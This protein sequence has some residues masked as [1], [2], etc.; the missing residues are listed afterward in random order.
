MFLGPTLRTFAEVIFQQRRK[1]P[2][3]DRK[4][5]R[6]TRHPHIQ[7]G[8]S[9]VLRNLLCRHLAANNNYSQKTVKWLQKKKKKNQAAP[10]FVL[11]FIGGKPSLLC[12]IRWSLVWK[13]TGE[14][15]VSAVHVKAHRIGAIRQSTVC[16]VKIKKNIE[17]RWCPFLFMAVYISSTWT[18]SFKDLGQGFLRTPTVL[19]DA[20]QIWGGSSLNDI[21][22][23]SY[24]EIQFGSTV[25]HRQIK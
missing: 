25:T 19:S 17:F 21:V 8:C 10:G 2:Q 1:C 15:G 14:W 5:E 24:S 4:R 11:K 13:Q 18:Q 12:V 7:A 20:E 3:P 23:I 16:Y 9:S 22:W 6:V